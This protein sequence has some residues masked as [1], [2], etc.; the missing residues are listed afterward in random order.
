MKSTRIAQRGRLKKKL[1]AAK[2]VIDFQAQLVNML[3]ET[4]RTKEHHERTDAGNT[5]LGK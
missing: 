4:L 5:E 3:R 2:K 1:H